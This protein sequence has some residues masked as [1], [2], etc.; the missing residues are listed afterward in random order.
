MIR[1]EAMGKATFMQG[2][3]ARC[4][5]G[6]T[7]INIQTRERRLNMGSTLENRVLTLC[8]IVCS[9]DIFPKCTFHHQKEGLPF[10]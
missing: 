5:F 7:L 3:A 9:F 1:D 10:G 6:I 8:F 2:Y 4:G